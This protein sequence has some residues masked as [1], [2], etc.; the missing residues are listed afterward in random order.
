MK[1]LMVC[2]GNICRSPLAEGILKNTAAK[3]GLNWYIDSAGTGNYHPGEPP[4]EL[5]IKVAKSHKI[6]ISQQKARQFKSTDFI[7]FDKILVMDI[8]N[9]NE[10]KRMSGN[11]FNPEKIDLFLNALYPNENR[12]VPDPWYGTEE[13]FKKVFELISK[14]ANAIVLH[15]QN[16][17][18]SI[19]KINRTA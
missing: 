4:H 3:A 5:S 7:E 8:D 15:H 12:S 17:D 13:S 18:K 14:T 2:L 16:L 9:Y 10:V 1:I 11:L 6:D 19:V